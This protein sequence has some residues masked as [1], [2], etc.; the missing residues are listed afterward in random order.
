MW[1]VNDI[2]IVIC[3]DGTGSSDW[4]IKIPG[5]QS[6]VYK[7]YEDFGKSINNGVIIN[8]YK[9]TD[10]EIRET[11]YMKKMFL[12]GPNSKVTGSDSSHIMQLAQSFITTTTNRVLRRTASL[13][14]S[15]RF[16]SVS[17]KIDDKNIRIILVGHSRGGAIVLDIARWVK[18]NLRKEIYFMGL[19]DAVDM[20]VFIEGGRVENTKFAFHAV[21]NALG[22]RELWRNA[23]LA[24]LPKQ[25]IKEFET[26]HGG[27]GGGLDLNPNGLFDDYSC[28]V[29]TL[30]A[31]IEKSLGR[32]RGKICTQES[33]SSYTWMLNK[34]RMHRLPI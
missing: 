24:G 29:D 31:N 15:N 30:S 8:S 12:D 4:R 28:S 13:R 34:A 33:K 1:R 23:G 27:I 19:F 17:S 7:F 25:N 2:W 11:S 20:S 5:G 21:R 32:D 26:S 18:N 14:S 9:G 10:Y 3:I 6:H 22:S 16:Y